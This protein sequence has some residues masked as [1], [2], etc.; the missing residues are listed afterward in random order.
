MTASELQSLFVTDLVRH[1]SG[2]R[3]R[4]RLIVGDVRVYSIATHAHCN[5]AVTPSGSASEND[6][7]ERLADRLRA[8][9]P[10]VDGG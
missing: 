10:I 9:H 4:W 7:V 5:W 1:N 8:D 6:A 2:D 3:R